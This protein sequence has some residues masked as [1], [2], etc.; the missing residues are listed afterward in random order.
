MYL[1]YECSE[2]QKFFFV[3][4]DF[5]C[6]NGNLYQCSFHFNTHSLMSLFCD[7]RRTLHHLRNFRGMN[8]L[9]GVASLSKVV[10]VLFPSYKRSTLTGKN[11]LTLE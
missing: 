1:F 6:G 3:M 7:L 5:I 2:L 4:F 9:L 11:L 8:L 10:S